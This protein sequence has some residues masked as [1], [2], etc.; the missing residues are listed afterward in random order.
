MEENR[1]PKK[2]RS[3]EMREL[4]AKVDARRKVYRE[5][6]TPTKREKKEE[7]A[8]PQPDTTADEPAD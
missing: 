2:E 1:A 4:D 7:E 3:A 5:G 6:E 8:A